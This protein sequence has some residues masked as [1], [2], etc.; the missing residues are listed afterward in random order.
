M[1]EFAFP[2]D[3]Q[4]KENSLLPLEGS[5]GL[6]RGEWVR[7]LFSGDGV[8]LKKQGQGTGDIA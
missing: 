6:E 3:P 4:T 8:W 1:A 5:A 7:F 2:P